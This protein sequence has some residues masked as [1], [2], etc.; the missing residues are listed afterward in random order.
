LATS[1]WAWQVGRRFIQP[2]SDSR[3]A[4]IEKK[5]FR[6][7]VASRTPASSRISAAAAV[8]STLAALFV[9]LS[10]RVR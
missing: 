5:S 9:I 7:H 6:A 1:L 3:G 2:T 8:V 4:E 10:Q